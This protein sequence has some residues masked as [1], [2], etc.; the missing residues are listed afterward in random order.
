MTPKFLDVLLNPANSTRIARVTERQ[1]IR[2]SD[3][4]RYPASIPIY[5]G[6]RRAYPRRLR[7]DTR[8]QKQRFAEGWL[9]FEKLREH[10]ITLSSTVSCELAL[11]ARPSF[12]RT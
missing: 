3:Y 7:Q 9:A 2:K 4:S 11:P 6:P 12:I 5:T 8:A 1:M 10:P